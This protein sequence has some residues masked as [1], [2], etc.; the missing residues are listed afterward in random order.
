MI[1]NVFS[2]VFDDL[3]MLVFHKLLFF[4]KVLDNL[5]EGFLKNGNLS[6]VNLNFFGLAIRSVLILILG[7]LIEGHISFQ[8]FVGIIQ[9]ADLTLVI[10]DSVSLRNGFFVQLLVFK[11]D[12]FLNCLDSSVCIL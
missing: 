7:S 8:I 3:I 6:L 1:N 2:L 11:V 10:I 12:G 5:L 4:F 9:I